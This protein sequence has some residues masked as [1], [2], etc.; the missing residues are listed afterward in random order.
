[1]EN[2]VAVSF[3]AYYGAAI[4]R[5]FWTGW[6]WI[7]ALGI[8]ASLL[9]AVC[10]LAAE[11]LILFTA[12]RPAETPRD[13]WARYGYPTIRAT[14]GGVVLFIVI[15]FAVT[16]IQD[17]PQ[18]LS[19]A[20]QE[21]A[22]LR[23]QIDQLSPHP[24]PPLPKQFYSEIEKGKIADHLGELSA[25]LDTISSRADTE[26]LQV[27]S[28]SATRWQNS[29]MGRRFYPGSPPP[30]SAADDTHQVLAAV[31]TAIKSTE[32]LKT[33]LF[34]DLGLITKFSK[35][36]VLLFDPTMSEIL[37]R[38]DF[39]GTLKPVANQLEHCVNDLKSAERFGPKYP[40]DTQLLLTLLGGRDCGEELL[41]AARTFKQWIAMTK[42]R[43]EDVRRE[44]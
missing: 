30:P 13:W 28:A 44:L 7:V 19:K 37:K 32:N 3:W 20:Q 5:A 25:A 38:P 39:T 26:L 16:F 12:K 14:A 40:D 22:A 23:Q 29:F 41:E 17:A 43:V 33:I 35:S 21:A 8:P 6:D 11:S 18:Q 27:A 36:P 24:S 9:L 42:R 15:I 1:M 31:D 4:P 2:P 34:K 10:I